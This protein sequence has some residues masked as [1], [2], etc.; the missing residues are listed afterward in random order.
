MNGL[1]WAFFNCP[2]QGF[3][4][5]NRV[6]FAQR[7]GWRGIAQFPCFRAHLSTPCA[8]MKLTL[9]IQLLPDQRQAAKLKSTIEQFNRACSW[10]AKQAFELKTANKITLQQK[11]YYDLREKFDLSAQ[12]AAICIRHVGGTYSR[13][14]SILPVFR[15]DAAMP[16]DSRILSFKGIDRVSILTLE[17]RLIIPFVM[18]KYQRER[19]SLAKGEC[20]IARRK[21]GKWFLLVTVDVPEGTEITPTEFVGV[22]FGVV[23]LAT[24]NDGDVYINTETE[25]VRQKQNKVRRSLGRRAGKVKRSGSRPKNIKRKL[26]ALSGK[27]RRFKANE[28]HRIS[29]QIVEKATDTKRGI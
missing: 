17:G 3:S 14:K 20:D 13:D 8:S 2:A 24:D 28:N 9:Q 1:K 15:P 26:K 23:N 18:G 27:E 7:F 12:M 6:G 19:F 22:D 10:L 11:F 16:Y 21:D 29:K 5:H 4:I 25:K